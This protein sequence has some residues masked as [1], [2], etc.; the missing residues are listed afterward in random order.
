MELC[1][2]ENKKIFNPE[3]HILWLD[4]LEW[5]WNKGLSDKLKLREIIDTRPA[6]KAI[7]EEF[8]QAEKKWHDT[9]TESYT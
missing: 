2:G 5:R 6:L 3:F 9:R 4:F 7:L 1:A 8:L